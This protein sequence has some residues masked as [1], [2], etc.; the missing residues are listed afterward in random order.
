MNCDRMSLSSRR[1]LASANFPF[2][3]C[4][5]LNWRA[6]TTPQA[7]KQS[8]DGAAMMAHPSKSCRFLLVVILLVMGAAGCTFGPSAPEPGIYKPTPWQWRTDITASPM[9]IAIPTTNHNPGPAVK[10]KARHLIGLGDLLVGDNLANTARLKG[11]QALAVMIPE[12]EKLG[13]KDQFAPAE[14]GAYPDYIL[15]TTLRAQD[16]YCLVEYSVVFLNETTASQQ[17]DIYYS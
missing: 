4:M 11:T 13:W 2:P 7:L 5:P 12:L 17:L 1:L 15:Y 9:G 10:V 8:L 14:T 6:L 3:R 16:Y